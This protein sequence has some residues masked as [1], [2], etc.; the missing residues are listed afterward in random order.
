MVVSQ[1]KYICSFCA[2]AFSRSEHRTRHERSHTG[3][4]PFQCKI[5]NHSFVRRDLVQRHIRTVHRTFLLKN[6]QESSINNNT[7]NNNNDPSVLDNLVRQMIKII[8]GNAKPELNSTTNALP[9]TSTYNSGNGDSSSSSS[10]SS[11]NSSNSSNGSVGVNA[12]K[13]SKIISKQNNGGKRNRQ[14]TNPDVKSTHTL[15]DLFINELDL[16][17]TPEELWKFYESGLNQLLDDGF[18][19]Q[20]IQSLLPLNSITKSHDISTHL[21]I[22]CIGNN[23]NSLLSNQFWSQC[24]NH[25]TQSNNLISMS[26]LVL[27]LIGDI[28]RWNNDVFNCYQDF[29]LLNLPKYAISSSIWNVMEIWGIGLKF[30]EIVSLS[31]SQSQIY[32]WFLSQKFIKNL[33]LIDFFNNTNN[34]MFFNHI[35]GATNKRRLISLLPVILYI[36]S[37]NNTTNSSMNSKFSL[38]NFKSMDDIH[39]LII[40][41]N[42]VFIHEFYNQQ[43][44]L[45][46][47]GPQNTGD[48]KFDIILSHAPS[49]F[50]TILKDYSLIPKSI[51]QWLLLEITWFDFTKN[52]STTDLIFK[53]NWYL[54]NSINNNNNIYMDSTMINNNLSICS[55][56]VILLLENFS[57]NNSNDTI[58]QLNYYNLELIVDIITVQLKIFN[59]ELNNS[60]FNN[61]TRILGFLINPIIQLLFYVWYSLLYRINNSSS[62]ISQLEMDSVTEFIEFFITNS[63]KRIDTEKLL[64]DNLNVIL[65]DT[66]SNYNIG[67]HFLLKRI[68]NY[69]KNDII[70]NKL[71]TISNLQNDLKFK[72]IEFLKFFPDDQSDPIH[73]GSNTTFDDYQFST[74]PS[75]MTPRHSIA[76]PIA[77]TP[78]HSIVSSMSGSPNFNNSG[79]NARRRSSI[80]SVTEDGKNLLL[81]P[82]NFHPNL[83]L[84]ELSQPL[85]PQQQQQQQLVLTDTTE[86]MPTFKNDQQQ[87]KLSNYAYGTTTSDSANQH[88]N[89]LSTYNMSEAL[90]NKMHSRNPS[91]ASRRQSLPILTYSNDETIAVSNVN[92]S[93]N[94]NKHGNGNNNNNNSISSATLGRNTTAPTNPKIQLPSPSQ[95]FGI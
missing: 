52:F 19:I 2:K 59:N 50:Q 14:R 45:Q 87:A 81:P 88:F 92:N 15:S 63:E 62:N 39:N 80:I 8:D 47:D 90:S 23:E 75:S 36:E 40:K 56:P 69:L 57:I 83:K 20:E 42:Q 35:L 58:N 95:L 6:S 66:T 44:Q 1:R 33:K 54:I 89:K 41:L 51:Y 21:A 7:N 72:V 30:T 93:N 86:T 27:T 67:Y 64:E 46:L 12:V 68:V 61:P 53:E 17:Y 94:I 13:S 31:K 73:S 3:F 43:Q 70:I 28:S 60:N 10:N 55:L 34:E 26:I 32:N 22:M 11:K 78:R 38:G 29:L 84:S 82:L 5:C 85:Q 49:K 65:F 4:K 71:L 25:S 48:W 74:N 77:D 76:S 9:L 18:F 37:L 79:I 16:L 91:I 24:W